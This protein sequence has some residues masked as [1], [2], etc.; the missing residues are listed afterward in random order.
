MAVTHDII[1]LHKRRME[2][3]AEL[4]QVLLIETDIKIGDIVISRGKLTEGKEYKVTRSHM[5]TP[6][7]LYL[8][9]KT[10]KRNGDWT[11]GDTGIGDKWEKK[12]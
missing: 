7:K 5:F 11:V 6:G 9:G 10:R 12:S 8:Y 2:L 4:E 1:D 3:F